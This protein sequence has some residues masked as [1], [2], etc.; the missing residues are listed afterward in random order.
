MPIPDSASQ[1]QQAVVEGSR[2]IAAGLGNA[3]QTFS[4]TDGVF[5]LDTA[6]GVGRVFGAL[7]VAQGRVGALFAAARLAVR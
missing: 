7:R 6:A 3:A 1:G 4:P 2:L 5:D